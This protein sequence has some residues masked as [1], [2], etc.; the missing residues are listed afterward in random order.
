MARISKNPDERKEEIIEAARQLFV[1]KGFASTKVSDIVKRIKVSQGVFY[2]YFDSKDAIVDE[3][4]DGYIRQVLKSA[5]VFLHSEESNPLTKIEL[6]MKAQ[7]GVNRALNSNIHT[8]KGVDI[9]ERIIGRLVR[10]YVPL[11]AEALGGVAREENE[12]RLEIFVSAG[13]LLFD[14]GIFQWSKEERDKR[15]DFYIDFMEKSF[16]LEKGSFFFFR[17][18]LGHSSGSGT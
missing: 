16:N 1:E 6:M 12:Y 18:L 4:I 14:P 17:E 7:F 8:I 10:E 5:G 13:N 11:L 9:H 15:I 2:Y 3:I